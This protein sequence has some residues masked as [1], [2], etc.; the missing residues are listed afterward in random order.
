MIDP[1]VP[2]AD[3]VEEA[4]PPRPAASLVLLRGLEAGL[5][6]LDVLM[7]RRP[8][9]ARFMPGIYVFPGGALDPSDR[10]IAA[11]ALGPDIAPPHLLRTAEAESAAGL[12]WAALRE[13]W[14]E[15]GVLVGRPGLSP[16]GLSPPG[17]A[18]DAAL[19]A[20]RE[21]GLGPVGVPIHYIARAITPPISPIR[22]DTRFF[23]AFEADAHGIPAA[24]DELSSVD[25]VQ[26]GDALASPDVRGISKFVLRHALSLLAGGTDLR[27]PDR[28][29]PR[30]SYEGDQ[31]VVYQ[32]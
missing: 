18:T 7:G 17:G 11:H 28:M 27:A 5:D 31:R 25:W 16:P 4:V 9:S 2:G 10:D 29:V 8:E 14:E 23:L 21:A 20:Y 22:F 24:S 30:Y 3:P 19:S 1:P 12:L 26:A 6:N 32:E 13:T 15:T